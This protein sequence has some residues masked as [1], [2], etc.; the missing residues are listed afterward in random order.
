LLFEEKNRLFIER[1]LRKAIQENEFELY[2]Q[3]IWNIKEKSFTRVEALIRWNHPE[4]GLVPPDNFIPTAE[5]CQ[6]MIPLG[7][8]VFRAACKQMKAWLD[9]KIFIKNM[10][11]N[12]SPQQLKNHD[13]AAEINQIIDEVGIPPEYLE[14]E[15]T[16]NVLMENLESAVPLL[17]LISSTGVG[18][19][20]DDFGTGYSSLQYLQH[21]P[22]N[23]IKIDRTFVRDLESEEDAQIA[24]A[25]VSLGR[26]FQLETIA[27]GIETESQK[28][29]MESI[30][31]DYLQGYFFCKPQ[32]AEAATKILSA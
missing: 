28:V 22:L 12:V 11:V 10:A 27:E 31:C 17:Q 29:F 25:I 7:N 4:K 24:K 26:S 8:W 21:F 18:I 13:I 1:D 15:I 20:L 16:E 14:L 5:A 19:T 30:G 32:K 9:Q 3:P 6:L 2:Y 23:N